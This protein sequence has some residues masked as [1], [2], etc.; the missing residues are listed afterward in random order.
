MST[1]KQ[2]SGIDLARIWAPAE[3][4]PSL[5][6]A[7][8]AALGEI[9]QSSA[10]TVLSTYN[11]VVEPGETIQGLSVAAVI[12]FSGEDIAGALGVATSD[13]VLAEAYRLAHRNEGSF[14]LQSDWLRELANQILGRV[15]GQM[16]ERGVP[17]YLAL[18]QTIRGMR[19]EP[20][21]SG[22]HHISWTVAAGPAGPILTWLELEKATALDL[23]TKP[24]IH[25][26]PSGD[27][28]L[29]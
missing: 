23:H 12:G 26:R 24:P 8:T 10:L 18:P 9:L 17:I 6:P 13:D 15:K 25:A 4:E 21:G 16:L 3:P 27:I 7:T 28:L 19:L 11:M 29:F 20:Q 5:A 22:R 1:S 2:P 14:A